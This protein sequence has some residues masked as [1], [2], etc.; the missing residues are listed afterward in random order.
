MSALPATRCGARTLDWGRQTYVMAILN[1]TPDSVSF[2][3][4]VI[5]FISR[6][7]NDIDTGHFG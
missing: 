4:Y 7:I 6:P 2:K 1:L 3:S 5:N